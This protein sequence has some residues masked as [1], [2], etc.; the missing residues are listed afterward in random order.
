MRKNVHISY[1]MCFMSP[2]LRFPVRAPSTATF[3]IAI[4]SCVPSIAIFGVEV[5]LSNVSVSKFWVHRKL[6]DLHYDLV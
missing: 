5:T 1:C 6:C 2:R 3:D 4:F